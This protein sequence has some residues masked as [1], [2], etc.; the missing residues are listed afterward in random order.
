MR[1]NASG[2]VLE[3]GSS[4]SGMGDGPYDT[5]LSVLASPLID[6]LDS[7]FADIAARL[8]PTGSLQ[9]V[10]PQLYVGRDVVQAVRRAGLFVTDAHRFEVSSAPKG[11]RSLV[12]ASA[13]FPTA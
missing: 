7:F 3:L 6:D 9:L 13:R 1:A 11:L 4:G 2:R 12:H 5:V 8:S 10:E